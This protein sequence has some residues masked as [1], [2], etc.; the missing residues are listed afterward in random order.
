MTVP[1]HI[2]RQWKLKAGDRLVVR[3]SDEGIL[4]Y[5]HYW[6]PY[7]QGAWRLHRAR[8]RAAREAAAQAKAA[9]QRSLTFPISSITCASVRPED[10]RTWKLWS[11][12]ST[13]CI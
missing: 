2:A 1:I 9:S 3:S 7:S 8:A 5:P 12:P 13:Q 10:L 4:I 11:A 6:A